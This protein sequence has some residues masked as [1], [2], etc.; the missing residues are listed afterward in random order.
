MTANAGREDQARCLAA[1]MD[2]F[3]TKPIAP[4]LLFSVLAKWMVRRGDGVVRDAASEAAV[5]AAFEADPARQRAVVSAPGADAE[6]QGAG[7]TAVTE[8]S[9]P[10]SPQP[11]PSGAPAEPAMLDLSALGQTFGNRQD[12][13]R[14]YALLFLDAAHDSLAEINEAAAEGDLERL[15]D[16]GHRTKSSARAVGAMRFA[17]RCH[18]LEGFRNSDDLPAALRVVDRLQPLLDLL[19]EQITQEFVERDAV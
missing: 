3:I 16:L 8:A 1:G 10:A 9:A 15:A 11:L 5:E 4:N 19:S 13:M 7:E 14:K 18:A 17:A 2:E 12:K 6:P